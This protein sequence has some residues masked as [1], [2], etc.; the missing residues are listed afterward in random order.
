MECDHLGFTILHSY[1]RRS[2]REGVTFRPP[3]AQRLSAERSRPSRGS[4]EIG[5][6]CGSLTEV[7]F[8]DSNDINQL[9]FAIWLPPISYLQRFPREGVDH[10]RHLPSKKHVKKMASV[11]TLFPTDVR[12]S[13]TTRPAGFLTQAP[14]LPM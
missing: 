10:N 4:H 2:P 13:A 14:R 12:H 11:R 1:S 7:P 8:V 5:A 3:T 6:S 9:S